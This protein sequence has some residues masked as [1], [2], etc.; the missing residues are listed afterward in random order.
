MTANPDLPSYD[1]V[2][3]AEHLSALLSF[4]DEENFVLE[5]YRLADPEVRSAFDG[6]QNIGDLLLQAAQRGDIVAK[7]DY[8]LVLRSTATSLTDLQASARWLQ[9]A[10]DGGDIIAMAEFGRALAYGIGIPQDQV[11]A[12]TWLEQAERAGNADAAAL[13]HLLRLEVR[14]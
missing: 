8:A 3:A 4:A 1:P 13:A 10:A 2:A 9:E 7:R 6:R 14:Q 11:T 5:N 12:L